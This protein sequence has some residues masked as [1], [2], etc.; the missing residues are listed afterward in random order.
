LETP[1]NIYAI[2]QPIYEALSACADAEF[3]VFALL[4][5]T[6][7]DSKERKKEIEQETKEI[8]DLI[9]LDLLKDIS[10]RY[11]SQI[12]DCREEHGHG[13]KVLELTEAGI[14]M[15]SNSNERK[16]N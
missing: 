2:T 14:L 8:E 3:Y 4:E 1:I 12:K 11:T 16:V 13:Y 9:N 6:H 10:Y 5:P 15:F 7:D